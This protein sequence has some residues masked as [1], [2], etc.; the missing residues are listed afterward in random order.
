MDVMTIVYAV[1]ASVGYGLLFYVRARIQNQEPFDKYKLIATML[2]AAVIGGI[3]AALGLPVTQLE[4]EAQ[5]TLYFV[6][7]VF[8]ENILKMLFPEKLVTALKKISGAS[9]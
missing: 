4:V 1:L 2:S 7:V 5:L 9:T 3:S 8:L 6:Y